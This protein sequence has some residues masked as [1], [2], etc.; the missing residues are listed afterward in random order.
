MNTIVEMRLTTRKQ[1]GSER[2]ACNLKFWNLMVELGTTFGWKPLGATYVATPIR[3]APGSEARKRDYE[4]G[5][6]RDAKIV[7]AQDASE[8]ANALSGARESSHFEK[9]TKLR[10]DSIGQPNRKVDIRNPKLD[11]A[12]AESVGEFIQYL[13]KGAFSF[14]AG[15]SDDIPLMSERK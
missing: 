13:H 2:F 8:W 7:E 12:F 3:Q 11:A 4:P 5:T 1:G 14:A 15:D 9:L 10:C 6:W